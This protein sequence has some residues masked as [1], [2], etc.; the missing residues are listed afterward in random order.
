MVLEKENLLDEDLDYFNEVKQNKI[1][2]IKLKK[3]EQNDI[4]NALLNF[5][6]YKRRNV[7]V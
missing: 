7:K 2:N 4:K 1:C 5:Q 6:T 3:R